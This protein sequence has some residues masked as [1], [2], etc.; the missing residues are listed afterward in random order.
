MAIMV[1]L[2]PEAG[3]RAVIRK[4]LGAVDVRWLVDGDS[5]DGVTGMLSFWPRRELASAG[6]TST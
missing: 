6:L 3:E 2:H 4:M 5:R 1:A